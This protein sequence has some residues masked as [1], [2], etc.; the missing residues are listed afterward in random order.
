MWFARRLFS[1]DAAL[2]NAFLSYKPE[3]WIKLV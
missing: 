3:L 1:A 2:G